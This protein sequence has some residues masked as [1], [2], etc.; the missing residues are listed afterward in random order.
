MHA[1]GSIIIVPWVNI[2]KTLL[3]NGYNVIILYGIYKEYKSFDL[4]LQ[5]KLIDNSMFRQ[6]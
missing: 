4:T 3:A 6:L 5:C 2:C 1:V